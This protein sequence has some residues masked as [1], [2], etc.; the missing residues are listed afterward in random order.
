[1]STIARKFHISSAHQRQMFAH[2]DRRGQ[3][4][5]LP[6][7]QETRRFFAAGSPEEQTSAN[8]ITLSE[9]DRTGAGN[10]PPENPGLT[11]RELQVF[12]LLITGLS[13]KLIAHELLISHRTVEVHRSRLMRKMGVRN[14]AALVRLALTAA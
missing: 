11:A 2:V 14:A 3:V 10:F 12:D 8:T 1:M 5:M 13:N 4:S 6:L 7:T 9:F